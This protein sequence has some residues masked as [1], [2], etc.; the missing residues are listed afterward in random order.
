MKTLKALIT[1]DH[2]STDSYYCKGGKGSFHWQ[3][4]VI[5]GNEKAVIKHLNNHIRYGDNVPET[6]IKDY[7]KQY[8]KRLLLIPFLWLNEKIGKWRFKNG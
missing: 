5:V 7:E 8:R 1:L 2:M 4:V 6:A 3:G